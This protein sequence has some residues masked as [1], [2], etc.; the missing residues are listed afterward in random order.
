MKMTVVST[1]DGSLVGAMYGHIESPD[2]IGSDHPDNGASFRGSLMA[3]PDQELH[4]LDVPDDVVRISSAPELHKRLES[5]I[6]KV[7][8]R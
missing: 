5:E 6:K 2:L 1:K 8:S 4:I 7:R 3:G